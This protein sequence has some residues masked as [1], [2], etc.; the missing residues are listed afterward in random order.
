LVT[1]DSAQK[2]RGKMG[3]NQGW[4]KVLAEIWPG[5]LF[6][7][8]GMESVVSFVQ[9]VQWVSFFGRDRGCCAQ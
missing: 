6:I 4:G 3:Q 2:T 5:N 1:A 8:M 9:I 7:L